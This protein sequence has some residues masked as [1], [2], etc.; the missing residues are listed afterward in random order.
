[1]ELPQFAGWAQT[2]H[3]SLNTQDRLRAIQ[4]FGKAMADPIKWKGCWED[5][6]GTSGILR[7]LSL[8]SVREIVAFCRAIR[9]SNRRGKKSNERERS[10]E[11]LVMALLPQHYPSSELRTEDRRSLQ[12]YYGWMLRGCSSSFVERILDAQDISNPLFQE[13]SLTKLLFAHEDMLKRR[14][15]SYLVYDGPQISKP[16][17]EVSLR[18]FVFR[19]PPSPS[20]HRNIGSIFPEIFARWKKDPDQ[21]EQLLSQALRLG[22]A[23]SAKQLSQGYSNIISGET[24]SSL[25]SVLRWRLLRLYCLYVPPNGIDIEMASDYTC[26]ANQ[27]WS[28]EV[29]DEL[30]R[31][32]AI[33]FLQRLDRVN[34]EFDFLKGPVYKSIYRVCRVLSRR[35]FNVEL[36]LTAHHQ[37]DSTAQQRARDEVDRLRKM[38]ATSREQDHRALLAK[39]AAYYAIATNDPNTYAETVLWQQRFVHDPDTLRSIFMD[40][41]IGTKEGIALLSGITLPLVKGTTLSSIQQRLTVANQILRVFN[42]TAKLAKKEPSYDHGDWQALS[43]LYADVFKERVARAKQAEFR[44]DMFNIIWLGTAELT[45]S[46]G[47]DFL[48]NVRFAILDLL[49]GLS[50]PSLITACESLVDFAAECRNN[51]DQN[52]HLD[53]IASEVEKLSCQAIAKLARTDTPVLS[54]NLIERAIIEHPEASSWHRQ[55]LTIGYLRN[56]PAEA[57]KTMLISFAI[58]IGEKL[59]EQSYVKVGDS[60]PPQSAP[61]QSLIKVTTVKYLAQ[62]LN[63]ADFVAP[64]SAIEVL[65]ELF[66]AGT[67]IDIRL[68]AVD[69]LL[70]T[71]NTISGN[72][73]RQWKSDPMVEKTF[74]ALENIILI[75]GN[76]NERRPMSAEGWAEAKEQVTIPT[77]SQDNSDIPPL[78]KAILD[79]TAGERYSNLKQ[80]EDALFSRLVLPTLRHSQEQHRD[81]FSLFLTKHRP[82]L[83]ADILPRVPI[84][85][86]IWYQIL[87]NQG[88]LLPPSIVN[89]FSQYVILRM[90]TPMAIQEFNKALRQDATLRNNASV[91][92]WLSIFGEPQPWRRGIHCLLNLITSPPKTV[93]PTSV[94]IN[95]IVS[96]ASVLLDDYESCIDEWRYL[97]VSMRPQTPGHDYS[98]EDMKKNWACWLKATNALAQELIKLLERKIASSAGQEDTMLPSTFPLRLLCLPYADP[99]SLKQK[100]ED[101]HHF[102]ARLDST[103]SSFLETNE[104][105]VLLW[106]TF[107]DIVYETLISAYTD[108]TARLRLAIHVG[109]LSI[110]YIRLKPAVQLIKVSVAL[111]L[112]EGMSKS[113][114]L[115]KPKSKIT[116]EVATVGQLVRRLHIVMGYW[117]QRGGRSAQVTTGVRDIIMQWKG[118]NVALWRDICSWDPTSDKEGGQAAE[119]SFGA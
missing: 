83:K 82:A 6:G 104:G 11:E 117:A 14:L 30:D 79:I 93:S 27:Q 36:Y 45:H 43:S 33:L 70:N 94:L 115:Q 80:F 13:L 18:E 2:W 89:E 34:P 64:D 78:F 7:L 87:E 40:N 107:S 97:L 77:I 66:Q 118:N 92:H 35:N 96:Q 16:E 85:P 5:G 52:E 95:V 49:D 48:G 69:S 8:G 39:A 116:S 84:T 91:N 55:F 28:F 38:A 53:K 50:G 67:H 100:D 9:I 99:S 4:T 81:W 17:I 62:L 68:A 21:Y 102:S 57:A 90:R 74:T 60:E 108:S 54:Q 112:I 51:K 29:I 106:A 44:Y 25:N 61:P 75:A 46:I 59:E 109:D 37:G 71:L 113:K 65:L 41:A 15:T 12:K 105:D 114:A 3:D 22:L 88:H 31:E 111:K 110:D 32:H 119:S 98:S 101:C 42:D 86:E 72:T 73:V 24:I 47:S 58:A 20:P 63:D 1:M 103:L 56:L 26:L 10:V 19:E 23:G 76:I